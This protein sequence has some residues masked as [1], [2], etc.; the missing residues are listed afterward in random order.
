M[1]N[2]SENNKHE[3]LNKKEE[4]EKLEYKILGD[5]FIADMLNTTMDGDSSMQNLLMYFDSEEIKKAT[6]KINEN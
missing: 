2:K 5:L 6:K 3:N 1:N 4:L